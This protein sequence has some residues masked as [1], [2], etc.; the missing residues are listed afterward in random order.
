[1]PPNNASNFA[2]IFNHGND[3]LLQHSNDEVHQ[4]IWAKV[5][6]EASQQITK[7]SSGAQI[8]ENN[9]NYGFVGESTQLEILMQTFCHLTAIGNLGQRHYALVFPKGSKMKDEVSKQILEYTENGAIYHL[10]NKWKTPQ[11]CSYNEINEETN[12]TR[13]LPFCK[14]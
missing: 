14:L 2:P 3:N 12:F 8:V 5:D 10:K 1:M 11:N 13:A 6:L 9:A 4:K 7:L